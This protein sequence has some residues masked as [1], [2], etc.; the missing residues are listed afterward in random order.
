M[1]YTIIC[2]IGILVP[3]YIIRTADFQKLK[4]EPEDIYFFQTLFVMYLI[5][6]LQAV[7]DI[8]DL[9]IRQTKKQY[10]FTLLYYMCFVI[11]DM[12]AT[13]WFTLLYLLNDSIASLWTLFGLTLALVA[14]HTFFYHNISVFMVKYH[15][16]TK[17]SRLKKK[18][19]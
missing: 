1:A 13:L 7:V 16:E 18:K 14:G 12:G 6:I 5:T 11:V 8:L 15:N 4:L 10:K 17:I 19:K 3:I 9:A 2:A